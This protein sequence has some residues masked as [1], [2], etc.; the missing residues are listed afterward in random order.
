[1]KTG[2]T[3]RINNIFKYISTL[4]SNKCFCLLNQNQNLNSEMENVGSFLSIFPT[5]ISLILPPIYY[6]YAVERKQTIP[7]F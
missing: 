4:T 2:F 6:C 3:Y 5:H 1:M 7:G